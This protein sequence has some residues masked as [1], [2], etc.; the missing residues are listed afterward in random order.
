[1]ADPWIKMRNNLAT[2]PAVIGA[3]M[4]FG[5]DED[6]I[7]GKLHKL[8][9]WADTHTQDGCV[10]WANTAWLDRF[11]G[12]EGISAHLIDA[13]WL[14]TT[15]HG[16]TI[17]HFDRH[18]GQSA[19]R[20][21]ANAKHKQTGRTPDTPPPPPPA[22][23][24]EPVDDLPFAGP[25]PPLR[26]RPGDPIAEAMDILR[27]LAEQSKCGECD[28]L[29]WVERM[30]KD[31]GAHQVVKHAETFT[32]AD[33]DA[34]WDEWQRK[35]TPTKYAR[36]TGTWVANKRDARRNAAYAVQERT[37]AAAMLA[38]KRSA[39]NMPP[40]VAELAGQAASQTDE[41][42]RDMAWERL[43]GVTKRPLIDA[44]RAELKCNHEIA[45]NTARDRWWRQ[46]T[47]DE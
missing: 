16:L 47:E 7:V 21:A 39:A 3:A 26:Q 27:P 22:P 15:E 9:A 20:R 28:M 5:V 10:D 34:G 23:P 8:W 12:M 40:E 45:A 19:K 38:D 25:E 41:E 46:E 13:G 2:D 37:T 18:N 35:R 36:F 30:A 24:S 33:F 32:V 43:A 6:L 4:R 1:M 42:R 29:G 14:A 31:K 17:P 11:L 44:I